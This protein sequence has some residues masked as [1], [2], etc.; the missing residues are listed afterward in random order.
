MFSFYLLI[1]IIDI[2]AEVFENI[3]FKFN[4]I[5]DKFH[6]LASSRDKFIGNAFETMNITKLYAFRIIFGGGA[7]YSYESFVLGGDIFRKSLENDLFELFF[8]YGLMLVIPY[9][10]S[11]VYA[12]I[13][14]FK[15]RNYIILTVLTLTFLHSITMGHVLF[16]GTSVI[17][18]VICLALATNGTKITKHDF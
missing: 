6:F 14:C 3:I 15:E 5:D 9:I 12:S 7:Y 11:F 10:A 4:R 13:K 17:S 8:A 2:L 1:P 16:N 18:Y